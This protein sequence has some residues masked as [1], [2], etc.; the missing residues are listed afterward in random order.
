MEN[1]EIFV[2]IPSYRDNEL[3]PTLIDLLSKCDNKERI[4][5][6]ICLQD[7]EEYKEEIYKQ[8]INLKL[9]ENKEDLEKQ[10]RIDYVFWKEAKGPCWAR[11]RFQQLYKK[12][13]YYLSIDSH[14]R[15]IQS[16]DSKLILLI[17][18]C[19]NPSKSIITAYPTGYEL[20]NKIPT[21]KGIA[22][23]CFK[24]FGKDGMMRFTGKKLREEATK[25]GVVIESYFWVSGFSFSF[26]FVIE[27]V[28]YDPLLP[29][30]FFGE[31]LSMTLR[32]FTHGFSFYC[33]P[34]NLL[35]HLWQRDY[36]P[37]FRQLH[38]LSPSNNTDTLN[39]TD[40]KTE[41]INTNKDK[42]KEMSM[43]RVKFLAGMLTKKEI[44]EIEEIMK[45]ENNSDYFKFQ[46]LEINNQDAKIIMKEIDKYGL[47][48]ERT[49]NDFQILTQIDFT[50]KTFTE[51][52]TYGGLDK[53]LFEQNFSDTQKN[54]LFKLLSNYNN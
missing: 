22:F 41:E 30:L 20:P 28:P 25:E 47:G 53:N 49:V 37:N 5:I 51:K 33:P 52:S 12:E 27:K 15:F 1:D 34:Y 44:E 43:I 26:G 36:R 39:N 8:L 3:I 46:N 6:G 50:N 24:E 13:K 16:W 19:P 18:S 48:K 42:Q 54:L 2:G 40:N 29:F 32:L 4:K 9:F 10:I 17:N 7:E 23:L 14:M 21:E 38:T 31:E 35:F 11:Y 45:K